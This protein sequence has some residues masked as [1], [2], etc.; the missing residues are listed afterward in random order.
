METLVHPEIPPFYFLDIR[1]R[2]SKA[3]VIKNRKVNLETS[4]ITKAS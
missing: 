1:L 4:D 3:I 2:F